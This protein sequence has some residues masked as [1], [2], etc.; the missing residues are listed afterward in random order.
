MV[1][2]KISIVTVCYNSKGTI[3]K[4]IMSVK[5]Q[6]YK[7]VEYIVIDGG[8]TDGTIDII[9]KYKNDVIDICISEPDE[10]PYDAMNKALKRVSGDWVLFLNSDDT[11]YNNDVL[12][13]FKDCFQ[14]CNTIYYGNVVMVPEMKICYGEFSKRKIC[15]TNICHQSIF[16]PQCV[17]KKYE[18]CKKYKLYADWFL[19]IK[20]YSDNDIFFQYVNTIVSNFNTQ[21][22][23][24]SCFDAH[25]KKD[26]K[27]IIVGEFGISYY[28]YSIIYK[29]CHSIKKRMKRIMFTLKS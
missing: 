22:M 27:R 9:N 3:E 15:I 8:S 23:S 21:G 5:N 12:S 19:N 6:T 16:Y 28:I 1:N 24:M 13:T 18:Y 4:T 10:G 29:F 17:F 26:Y 25:F 7:N 20:C 11:F 14:D 2:P